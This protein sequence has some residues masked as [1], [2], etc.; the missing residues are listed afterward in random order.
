MPFDDDGRGRIAETALAN[1]YEGVHVMMTGSC[2][3]LSSSEGGPVE[4]GSWVEAVYGI[5]PHGDL[6]PL[7][8]MKLT[9]LYCGGTNVY[10]PQIPPLKRVIEKKKGRICFLEIQA[11]IVDDTGNDCARFF[12]ILHT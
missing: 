5:P 7:K 6:S 10:Q 3:K 11:Q 12:E 4:A 1:S 2:L 8:D 9:T